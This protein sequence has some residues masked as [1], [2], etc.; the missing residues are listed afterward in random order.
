M[1]G[2]WETIVVAYITILKLG[3]SSRLDGL[4]ILMGGEE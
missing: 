1:S 2:K 4:R 3:D